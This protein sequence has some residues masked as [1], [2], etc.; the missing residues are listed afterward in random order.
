[1]ANNYLN[2]SFVFSVDLSDEKTKTKVKEILSAIAE[3]EDED[4]ETPYCG[5]YEV[6]NNGIWFYTDEYADIGDTAMLV[7]AL[8]AYFPESYPGGFYFEWAATCSKLRLD[9]FYGGSWAGLY[10]DSEIREKYFFPCDV[11][12]VWL[13]E[14]LK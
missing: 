1:M 8:L 3:A 14:Q 13:D 7:K 12:Q 10:K 4:G 5:C 11:A 2:Y 6:R 9:E